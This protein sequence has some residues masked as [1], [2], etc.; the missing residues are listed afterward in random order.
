ME[1]ILLNEEQNKELYFQ[2]LYSVSLALRPLAIEELVTIVEH[3]DLSELISLSRS[4]FFLCQGILYL[5]HQSAKDYLVEGR[6]QK[7][8][9]VGI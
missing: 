5:I 4:F 9:T 6:A 8:F 3:D 7:L 1:Q 2:I